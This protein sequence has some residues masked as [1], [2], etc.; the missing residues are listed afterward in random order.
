M[1]NIFLKLW[2]ALAFVLIFSLNVLASDD[3]AISSVVY[4]NSSAVLTINSQ[5]ISDFAFSQPPKIQIN[6]A[7]H[8]AY[9]DINS[10]V[11]TAQ[12]RDLILNSSE[13]KEIHA[14]Q[15]SSNPNIVRFEISYNETYNPANIQLKKLNNTLFLRF[16]TPTISNYYFQHVFSD[17]AE[18]DLYEQQIVQIP[19]KSSDTSIAGQINSAF[20]LE[21]KAV[22]N[23]VL[24]KKDLM[25]SSKYYIDDVTISNN[26]PV[27][28]G[29]GS[30]TLTKPFYLTNPSRVVFDLP[31]SIVNP[32][33]RNKEFY[34]NN[35]DTIKIGQFNKNSARIV[36]S[37][38]APDRY[39][40]ILYSDT[41]RL[42]F[43]DKLEVNAQNL[44]TAKAELNNVIYEKNSEKVH[45]LKFVFSKP[46]VYGI[47]RSGGV[48]EILLYNV[49]KYLENTI[50]SAIKS[51]IFSDV[52]ISN[53]SRGG[54]KITVP[55]DSNDIIDIHSG[56]DGKT[57]RL[58]EQFCRLDLPQPKVEPAVTVTPITISTR[59]NGK[60]YVVIDPGHGGSDVGATRNGIYEKNIT[61][62]VSKKV[63]ALLE[64]K[65]FVVKMTRTGDQTVSL[66]ERVD[67]SEEVNP[68]IFVSIHVNSS[69]SDSP[70]GLETHYYK[71]NSLTLAK[72][73]HAALLNNVNSKDRG[74][75][76]SKFY[77]INH[78]TAPAILVEIGFISN[79]AERAQLVSES[80]K[81][82]TA[83]A[84]AEGIYDYFK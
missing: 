76:K 69:N 20:N 34:F 26:M 43:A 83:K 12:V 6:T 52:K 54:L 19:M 50:K 15:Y 81:Q 67:I 46:V 32:A 8:K 57:L 7:E 58:K 5:D 3:L 35:S 72:N 40:P 48:S 42:I 74:L 4:D 63:V 29:V 36:L 25:L 1:K 39:I 80:R 75:F 11:L 28:T 66:Q 31:N 10:A 55:T 53:N 30:Y 38:S 44:T 64:K 49:N 82:A 14:E 56:A 73:V 24:V 60:K 61:L 22:Q 23:Y 71:D 13:I 78:T 9:I 17:K 37:T 77:V 68:D 65:G 2:F 47:E 18:S 21:N 33:I 41:Q 27:V 84:I 59:E 79:P 45:S 16:K 62:D 51:T 70:S